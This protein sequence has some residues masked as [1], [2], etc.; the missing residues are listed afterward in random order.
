MLVLGHI[1]PPF[2][3]ACVVAYFMRHAGAT[4]FGRAIVVVALAVGL[5]ALAFRFG[6]YRPFFSTDI[7][8]MLGKVGRWTT[9][10]IEVLG[11][12]FFSYR[13]RAISVRAS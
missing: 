3:V 2:I 7:I 9:L 12:A 6:W 1:L 11:L 5:H 10:G 8:L 4:H 13:M